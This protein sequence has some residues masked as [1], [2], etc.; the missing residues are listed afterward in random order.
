[1][2]EIE[3]SLFR[4]CDALVRSMQGR[5][6][7]LSI[8]AHTEGDAQVET[9]DDTE[10]YPSTSSKDP[11]S[12]NTESVARLSE[13]M[14]RHQISTTCMGEEQGLKQKLCTSC[15]V[16]FGDAKQFREHS[17]TDWHKHNMARKTR[18]LPPLTQE[19]CSTEMQFGN[20]KDDLKDYNF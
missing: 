6:E 11:D 16:S 17:K 19:E 20:D 4:E 12:F 8:S 2:C 1:V 5:L 14:G 7:I 18:N 15:N 13:K 10:D 9:N 3:P